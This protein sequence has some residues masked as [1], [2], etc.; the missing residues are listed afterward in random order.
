MSITQSYNCHR[1]LVVPIKLSDLLTNYS[2]SSF[3]TKQSLCYWKSLTSKVFSK[4]L[5][6][7][8]C[9]FVRFFRL[10]LGHPLVHFPLNTNN[11]S[12]NYISI[13]ERIAESIVTYITD[14]TDFGLMKMAIGYSCATCNL[15]MAFPLTS[16]IQCFP[17]I[18]RR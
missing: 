5:L 9:S 2:F 13:F 7:L 8:Q 4:L 12:L 18:G 11:R 1:L 16:R 15:L 17:Y 14:S 10:L 3:V 6:H